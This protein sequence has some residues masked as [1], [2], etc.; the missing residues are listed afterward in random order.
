MIKLEH[1][2]KSYENGTEVL[3]DLSLTL[4]DGEFAF[5]VGP[6]GSDKSTIIKLLTGEI[7][8]TEGE[9][10][11]N[12]YDMSRIS[13]RKEPKHRRSLGVKFQDFRLI[14]TR[15]STKNALLP[16]ALSAPRAERLKSA[17]LCAVAC[18]VSDMMYAMPKQLSA[19]SSRGSP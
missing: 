18:W 8:C 1:V 9:V 5:L 12:G 10:I 11:V 16:C 19:E 15:T 17:S 4:E 3:K 6:S 13:G 14:E 2:Y 7:S